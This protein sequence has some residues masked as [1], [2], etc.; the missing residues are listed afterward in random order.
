[1]TT[2]LAKLTEREEKRTNRMVYCHHCQTMTNN[3]ILGKNQWGETIFA[4]SRTGCVRRIAIT[5]IPPRD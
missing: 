4:C 2:E 1:M 5:V 3:T